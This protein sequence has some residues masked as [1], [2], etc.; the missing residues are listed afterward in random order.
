M[1]TEFLSAKN[2]DALIEFEIKARETDTDIFIT[3]LDIEVLRLSTA[4]AIK[5]PAYN[6]AKCLLC[7]SDDG[8]II[9]RLDFTILPVLAFSPE[10]RAFVDWIYVLKNNRHTGAGKLLI[11]EMKEYAASV[12]AK[13]YFLIA[14]RNDEAQRFYRSFPDIEIKNEQVLI[15][16][17]AL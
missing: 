5:T 7:I 16:K 10:I 1:R 14:A 3:P 17:I 9:G 4:T 8:C 12:G 11:K 15:G 13:E 6:S 2:L